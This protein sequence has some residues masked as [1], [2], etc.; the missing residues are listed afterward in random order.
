ME[1]KKKNRIDR[2]FTLIELL[3]VIAI[4]ALLASIVMVSLNNARM[5]SRDAARVAN[6]NQMTK[7]FELYYND[8][9]S[10][11]T[12]T[13][14]GSLS[15]STISNLLVPNFL[16]KMPATINPADGSC[17]SAVGTSG[18]NDYYMYYNGATNVTNSYA[19]TF[20]LGSAVGPLPSGPHTLT[21]GGFQ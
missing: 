20:C 8:R 6:M 21:Q 16:I 3:V 14:A 5:K 13:S 2:G 18:S 15:T 12:N 11:P 19:I 10:Y 4:I 9:F 7:A 17:S 1:T